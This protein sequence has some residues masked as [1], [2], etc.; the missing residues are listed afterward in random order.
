MWIH[1]KNIFLKVEFTHQKI[2]S[3]LNVRFLN[4][5]FSPVKFQNLARIDSTIQTV[6]TWIDM[7]TTVYLLIEQ[8]FFSPIKVTDIS[9]G[10]IPFD[11]TLISQVFKYKMNYNQENYSP[12]QLI[13]LESRCVTD[14]AHS[15]MMVFNFF[16]TN[17]VAYHMH[18]G[19]KIWACK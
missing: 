18:I 12:E 16:D 9:L 5:N 10:N 15:G 4:E 7:P 8:N 13:N 1:N 2:G 19:N 6:C 14:L 3:N 17:P 11:S